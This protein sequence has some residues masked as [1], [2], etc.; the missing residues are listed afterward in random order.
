MGC[1]WGPQKHITSRRFLRRVFGPDAT[2][3]ILPLSTFILAFDITQYNSLPAVFTVLKDISVFE[4]YN[5]IMSLIKVKVRR[6]WRYQS[7]N[8]NPYI[9]AEQT[10]QWPKVQKDKQRSTKHTYKTKNRVT[11]TPIKT[12]VNPGAPEE[13]DEFDD[14]KGAIRI[15]ISKQNRQHNG[16]NKKYKRTNNDLQNIHITLKIE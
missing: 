1:I 12:G 11:R 3:Q 2:F 15:R 9:E 14:T 4:I 7:G 13:F 16:Q 8:H 6:V 10:T 5:K